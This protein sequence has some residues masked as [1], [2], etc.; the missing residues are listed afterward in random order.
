MEIKIE[1]ELEP[2]LETGRGSELVQAGAGALGTV[3]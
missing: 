3:P 1:M 2:E